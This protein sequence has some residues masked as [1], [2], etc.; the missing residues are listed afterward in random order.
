MTTTTTTTTTTLHR[1]IILWLCYWLLSTAKAFVHHHHHHHHLSSR[2]I[3]RCITSALV[4][5][6]AS[7]SQR[8]DNDNDNDDTAAAS[9]NNN[10]NSIHGDPLREA[11]G[12]RP[13]LHPVTINAIAEALKVR[14]KKNDDDDVDDD[15]VLSINKNNNNNNNIFRQTVVEPLQLATTAG[16]IA[17]EAL[18]KRQSSSAQDGMTL[19]PKEEQT[20]AGRVVGVVMRLD[21]L[22]NALRDKC[23]QAGW[24]AKYNEWGSFG[25]LSNE[26]DGEEDHARIDE[27]ILRDPLFCMNRAECLLALF[28]AQV[29]APALEKIGETVPG[30]SVVDFLDDDRKEVLLGD[31]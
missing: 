13:S 30:G 2:H 3:P 20:V 14:A 28:L 26:K 16:G 25:I 10:K 12:I 7:R 31:R 21:E 23:R 24:I 22:E 1:W 5:A 8:A 9:N 4:R 17:A 29:E 27:Q 11:T 18:Q 19:T 6:A 15:D